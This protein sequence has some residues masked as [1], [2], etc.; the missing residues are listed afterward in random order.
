MGDRQDTA[1]GC[2]PIG[3]L[4]GSEAADPRDDG[5]RC[6]L[7]QPLDVDYPGD[8]TAAT[9]LAGGMRFSVLWRCGGML[10]DTRAGVRH[11][12]Y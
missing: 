6:W 10:R 4:Q 2:Q 11:D 3:A 12:S 8:I 7:G 5:T 1:A 9:V